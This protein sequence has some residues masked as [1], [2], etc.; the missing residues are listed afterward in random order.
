MG[1]PRD[2]K[3]FCPYRTGR[4]EHTHPHWCPEEGQR[5]LYKPTAHSAEGVPVSK[6]HTSGSLMPELSWVC[7]CVVSTFKVTPLGGERGVLF[8]FSLQKLHYYVPN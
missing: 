3:A 2:G 6:R 5:G 4:T 1:V 7:P 8:P